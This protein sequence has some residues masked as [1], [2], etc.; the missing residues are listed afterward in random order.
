[1]TA[2]TTIVLPGIVAHLERFLRPLAA[3]GGGGV[4]IRQDARGTVASVCDGRHAATIS[5]TVP[6]SLE[7]ILVDPAALAAA[8][9][10]R[11]VKLYRLAET[12]GSIVG[13]SG[14]L[15]DV[16]IRPGTLPRSATDLADVVQGEIASGMTK[17]VFELD[18][19]HL[20]A[21]AEAMVATGAETVTITVAPRWNALAVIAES[22]ELLATFVVAGQSFEGPDPGEDE[23]DPL[24]FTIGERKKRT[25]QPIRRR[26]GIDISGIPDSEIP[27]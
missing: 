1:M 9:P 22:D 19:Q 4:E 17:T 26:K 14:E 13:A 3:T 18:P 8:D 5:T 23:D 15:V 21:V 7:P 12:T 24:T 20:L 2:P 11:P 27:W 25:A 16:V 10:S 6:G